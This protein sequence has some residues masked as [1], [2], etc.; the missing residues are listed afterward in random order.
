MI[1]T[2]QGSGF[3]VATINAD[4]SPLRAGLARRRYAKASRTCPPCP[5]CA[6]REP[7]DPGLGTCGPCFYDRRRQDL[8][9]EPRGGGCSAHLAM[10]DDCAFRPDS[11]EAKSGLVEAMILRGDG[12]FYCH[13][14]FLD[15]RT[16]SFGLEGRRVV[17]IQSIRHDR[18]CGGWMQTVGSEGFNESAGITPNLKII[19]ALGRAS[20]ER[21]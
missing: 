20:R 13:K 21:E 18:F 11:P 14:P 4:C 9:N 1:S 19:A 3:P 17:I 16:Q 6:Q 8:P 5:K 15:P 12:P 7:V 10:C 2:A